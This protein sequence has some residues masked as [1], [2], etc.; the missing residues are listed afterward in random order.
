MVTFGVRQAEAALALG[1]ITQ[2][3][4]PSQA[5]WGD[6]ANGLDTVRSLWAVPT[7]YRIELE[8]E[9]SDATAKA[10]SAKDAAL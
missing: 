2:E 1:T 3:I 5:D 6:V 7:A 9:L 4:L 10:D 8:K